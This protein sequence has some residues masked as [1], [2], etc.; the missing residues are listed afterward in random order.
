MIAQLCVYDQ[1]P[2]T[3]HFKWADVFTM[4]LLK[5]DN[6]ISALSQGSV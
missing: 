5:Y 2:S 4:K 1:K 6:Q 3:V